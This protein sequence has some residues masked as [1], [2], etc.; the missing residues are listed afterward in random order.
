MRKFTDKDV[1]NFSS[2]L[3]E[4]YNKVVPKCLRE[5]KDIDK[6]KEKSFSDWIER[7][8]N[9]LGWNKS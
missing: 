1:E 9:K 6:E 8:R 4:A 5:N 2:K 7:L 3:T